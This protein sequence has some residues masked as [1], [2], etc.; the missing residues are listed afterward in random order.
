MPK[1]ANMCKSCKN[2]DIFDPTKLAQLTELETFHTFHMQGLY[3]LGEICTI[4]FRAFIIDLATLVGGL[5][6]LYFTCSNKTCQPPGQ[7]LA[8]G[9][10][11]HSFWSKNYSSEWEQFTLRGELLTGMASYQG[12]F[13]PTEA[14]VSHSVSVYLRAILASGS[15]ILGTA[16]G[17]GP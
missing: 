8:T 4:H 1:C 15:V 7:T 12:K 3:L 9:S 13:V 10:H 17:L 5:P 2:H 6:C 16:V 14:C 11:R